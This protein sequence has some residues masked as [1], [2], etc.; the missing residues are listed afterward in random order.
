[1]APASHDD[2]GA[3]P[4]SAADYARHSSLQEAMASEVLALLNLAGDEKVLDI[5]CGDGRLSARI[6]DRL[7]R[8]E[9]VAVDASA[10]MV[11]FAAAAFTGGASGAR[12]NLRFAVAD[13]AALTYRAEFDRV[14]SFNALHWVPD[15]APALRGIAAALRA[16]GRA[17]L[18]LVV[19]GSLISLEEITESV[20]QS[21]RWGT[22]F[23]GFRDPYLRLTA[24]EYA[25][26]AEAQGLR[27][28]NQRTHGRA[29]DFKTD[30]AFFGFCKAGFGA[31]TRRLPDERRDGFVHDV[32]DAYRLAHASPTAQ[33]NV[34]RFY[35]M[36]ITLA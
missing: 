20:R 2:D 3:A 9:V 10:D 33:A 31:W 11:A 13:A 25:V 21:P 36:D 29:W 34:F 14:V 19:K 16:E 28:L 15:Q 27:V 22:R 26:L 12:S 8:G 1:M 7:P 18:R 4:W 23:E 5:G 6:A 35:Q 32:I 24:G 30:A 17:I